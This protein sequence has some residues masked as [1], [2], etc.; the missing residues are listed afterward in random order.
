MK[1]RVYNFGRGFLAIVIALVLTVS[2]FKPVKSQNLTEIA[3]INTSF[4]LFIEDFA[5]S[6]IPTSFKYAIEEKVEE[7][8][9]LEISG[10]MSDNGYWGSE[11]T[12]KESDNEPE[13][14][15]LGEEEFNIDLLEEKV[16]KETALPVEAWMYDNNFWK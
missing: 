10:W 13:Q 11:N 1:T 4:G 12:G 14:R 3:A 8:K 7:E 5:G 16:E 9:A 6:E 2:G 15:M